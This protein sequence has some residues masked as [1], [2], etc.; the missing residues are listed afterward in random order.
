[1]IRPGPLSAHAHGILK[2]GDVADLFPLAA[3][4]RLEVSWRR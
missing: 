2:V 3:A 1:M 4:K